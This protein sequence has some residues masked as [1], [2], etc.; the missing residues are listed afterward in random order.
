MHGALTKVYNVMILSSVHDK[1]LS[2]NGYH[3]DITGYLAN[4]I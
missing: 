3:T 2:I 4:I 1:Y